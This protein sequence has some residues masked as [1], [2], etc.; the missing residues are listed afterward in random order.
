MVIFISLVNCLLENELMVKEWLPHGSVGKESAC[1]AGDTGDGG[2][3]I[4]ILPYL[5]KSSLSDICL[6]TL[7]V[8]LYAQEFSGS[9]VF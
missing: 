5:E 2:Q 8:K 7:N 9:H 1:D 3:R 6:S 4:Y